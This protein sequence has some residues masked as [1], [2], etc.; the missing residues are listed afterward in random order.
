[1][2]LDS[3]FILDPDF[4]SKVLPLTVD[5]LEMLNNDERLVSSIEMFMFEFKLL[6]EF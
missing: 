4:F 2:L 3:L 5:E 1:M 6:A